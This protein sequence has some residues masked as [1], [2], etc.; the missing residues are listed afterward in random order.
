[1]VATICLEQIP[2]FLTITDYKMQTKKSFLSL[3]LFAI[4]SLISTQE[5]FCQK[6][7]RTEP[8]PIQKK[9]AI[10]VQ[11]NPYWSDYIISANFERIAWN[12]A[13]RY[14]S[15]QAYH[16][17]FSIG[18]EGNFYWNNGYYY[19]VRTFRF[20]P[21]FRYEF[22]NFKRLSLF[23]E[24]SPSINYDVVKYDQ[25]KVPGSSKPFVDSKKFSAGIYLAPGLSFRSRND[26]VSMDISYK[27]AT[28]YFAN[29][30]KYV[31]SFKI[32]YHF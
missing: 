24:T 18:L 27:A 1:M 2:N 22:L 16:T 7:G 6:I 29:G 3:F 8:M 11:F 28:Y 32:N 21:L 23:V 14:T 5:I 9:H 20:G 19:R 30:K 10:G 25:D 15:R 13:L 31:P 4:F 12:I 17:K 26:R